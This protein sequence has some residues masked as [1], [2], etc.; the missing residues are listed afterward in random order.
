MFLSLNRSRCYLVGSIY[1][2]INAINLE[3]SLVKDKPSSK[4]RLVYFGNKSDLKRIFHENKLNL[5]FSSI[6]YRR[7]PRKISKLSILFGICNSA[8]ISLFLFRK[9]SKANEV[10]SQNLIFTLCVPFNRLNSKFYFLEE[11]LSTYTDFNHEFQNRNPWIIRLNNISFKL[12]IPTFQGVFIYNN[13]LYDGKM[14]TFELPSLN[15]EFFTSLI[16][17]KVD[18]LPR[19]LFLGTPLNTVDS[20]LSDVLSFEEKEIFQTSVLEVLCNIENILVKNNVH[21]R[22]HPNE[23]KESISSNYELFENDNPWELILGSCSNSNVVISIFSTAAI[24]PKV[25]FNKEPKVVFLF[26]LLPSYSF[27]QAEEILS[28][29]KSIYSNEQDVIAPS[30]ILEL[31]QILEEL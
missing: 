14:K 26:R 8:I 13:S 17:F 18:F 9:L 19:K 4:A 12:L 23:Q 7:H 24:T 1:T 31:E 20:L 6:E 29:L 21:Y 11:G 22:P 2:L 3:E 30:T 10:F 28:R 5:L 16:K 15:I 25:L 27:Y